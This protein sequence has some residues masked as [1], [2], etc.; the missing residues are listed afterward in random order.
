MLMQTPT[1]QSLE[2]QTPSIASIATLV[3]GNRLIASLPLEARQGLA[4]YFESVSLKFR[5]VLVEFDSPIDYVYFLDDAVT[6]TVV[7]TPAGET[8][9]VGIMGSEGF[10]G[11]SLLYGIERSNATVVTQIPGRALRMRSED[12][13]RLVM[14]PGGPARDLLM[15]YA[16]FFQVMVQQHAACNVT[17]SVEQRMCRWILLTQDRATADSFSLTHE[18]LSVMLGVRRATVTVIARR[19][20]DE[21]MIDYTRGRLAVTNRAWLEDC[22]CECYGL[23]KEQMAR[24]FGRDEPRPAKH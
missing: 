23:I 17:H 6:S 3:P 7:R 22:S 10:V 20:K 14:Q 19:L 4:P 12:F 24:T 1:S 16:N 8:I 21:G 18:Y 15:R 2:R 5:Q 11:L 9:E 13:V